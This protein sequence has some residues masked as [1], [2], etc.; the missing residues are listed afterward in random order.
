LPQLTLHDKKRF[1]KLLPFKAFVKQNRSTANHLDTS[2]GNATIPPMPRIDIWPCRLNLSAEALAY[3]QH[4]LTAAE[5]ARAAQ[6]HPN[7]RN[8]IIAARGQLRLILAEYLQTPAADI[9]IAAH[10]HGKPYLPEHPLHFNLS[11]SGNH[12]LIAIATNP[13]GIDIETIAPRRNLE[14]L[15]QRCLSAKEL[16]YWRQ[17]PPEQRQQL[18]Y[19]LWTHKEAFVKAVGRGLSLGLA[20]CEFDIGETLT[21]RRIP[22]EYGHHQH[23]QVITLTLNSDYAAALAAPAGAVQLTLNKTYNPLAD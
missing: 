15:A 7:R 12:L 6:A 13:I 16:E 21:L 3:C 8:Q 10:P 17:T 19:R 20:A 5:H 2:P 1:D 22:K 18:F 4:N 23:W 9:A 11:H 14:Q